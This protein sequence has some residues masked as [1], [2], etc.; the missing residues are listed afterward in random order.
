[1]VT[2]GQSGKAACVVVTSA[3]SSSMRIQFT[4]ARALF[5]AGSKAAYTRSDL[6]LSQIKAEA[7]KP[8]AK[9]SFSLQGCYARSILPSDEVRGCVLREEAVLSI[10]S[11][12]ELF[13][14]RQ[15][16]TERPSLPTPAGIAAL[17]GSADGVDHVS[18]TTAISCRLSD[19]EFG[20]R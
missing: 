10:C 4:L 15:G 14:A 5:C 3:L 7:S 19:D 2:N 17:M 13:A 6:G 18:A 1:M 20:T 12:Q 9:R 11:S 16:S 8:R